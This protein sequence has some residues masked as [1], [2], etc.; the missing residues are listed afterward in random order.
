VLEGNSN[1]SD[2]QRESLTGG[3][4]GLKLHDSG[5]S[6]DTGKHDAMERQGLVR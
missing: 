2:T 4:R 6:V 1:G 5:E 3:V